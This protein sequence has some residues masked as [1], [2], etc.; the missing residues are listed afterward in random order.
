MCYT[1]INTNHFIFRRGVGV[2]ILALMIVASAYESYINVQNSEK[3]DTK[4]NND[5]EIECQNN[6]YT[7]VHENGNGVNGSGNGNVQRNGSSSNLS[8]NGGIASDS[9]DI[10]EK[11]VKSDK[12]KLGTGSY[13][14]LDI[15]YNI[16][17]V[18]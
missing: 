4:R 9:M 3:D 16:T 7:H 14:M 2:A 10:C 17:C 11:V 1:L 8:K 15:E 12:K 6:N 5:I 13:C 18:Y